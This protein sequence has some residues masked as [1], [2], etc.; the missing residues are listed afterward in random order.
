M[1]W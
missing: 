1:R